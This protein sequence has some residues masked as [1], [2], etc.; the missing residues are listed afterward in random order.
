M[1]NGSAVYDVNVVFRKT[2]PPSYDA[3]S[4]VG[5]VKYSFESVVVGV[6]RKSILFKVRA[7]K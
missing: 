7:Q 5:K 2:Q 3:V 1:L 4:G 6:Y